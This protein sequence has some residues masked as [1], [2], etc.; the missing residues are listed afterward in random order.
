M[1]R[2]IFNV[3]LPSVDVFR[4]VQR[5]RSMGLYAGNLWKATRG[6]GEGE[7]GRERDGESDSTWD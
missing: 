7:R 6:V 4:P 5:L 2:L 3:K 1:S